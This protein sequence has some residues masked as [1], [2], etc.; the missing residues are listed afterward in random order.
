MFYMVRKIVMG[1]L[2]LCLEHSIL[3]ISHILRFAMTRWDNFDSYTWNL[4]LSKFLQFSSK[5]LSSMK[6]N[7]SMYLAIQI[8]FISNSIHAD[9]VPVIFFHSVLRIMLQ[10]N[11]ISYHGIWN[12]QILCYQWNTKFVCWQVALSLLLYTHNDDT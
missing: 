7:K 11:F 1:G 4:V 9:H 8:Q 12:I 2:I 10:L 3:I 5:S 6:K